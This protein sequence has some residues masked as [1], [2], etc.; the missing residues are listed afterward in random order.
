L[1]NFHHHKNVNTGMDECCVVNL[2]KKT[3][4]VSF[5]FKKNWRFLG[6]GLEPSYSHLKTLQ[7]WF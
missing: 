3:L 6:C 4:S 5:G 1:E 7:I 2:L